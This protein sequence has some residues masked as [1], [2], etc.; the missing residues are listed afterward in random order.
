MIYKIRCNFCGQHVTVTNRRLHYCHCGQP[1]PPVA[2]PRWM[3]VD[4]A[5]TAG[6]VA[7]VVLTLALILARG[8]R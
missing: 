1:L 5:Y 8:V 4:V 3:W 6:A 7:L 2:G